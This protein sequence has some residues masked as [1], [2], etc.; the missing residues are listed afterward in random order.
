LKSRA[1]PRNTKAQS[2]KIC[3]ILQVKQSRIW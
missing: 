2:G 1:Q 3:W